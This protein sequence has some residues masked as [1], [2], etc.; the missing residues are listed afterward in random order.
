VD[1]ID[2]SS[3]PSASSAA[4]SARIAVTVAATSSVRDRRRPPSRAA[5]S[6]VQTTADALATSIPAAFSCRSWYSSSSTTCA[7]IFLFLR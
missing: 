4:A 3:T 7:G 2:T 1:S 6:R 5:G